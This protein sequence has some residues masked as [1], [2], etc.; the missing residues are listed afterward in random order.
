M[1]P[2]MWLKKK[3]MKQKEENYVNVCVLKWHVRTHHVIPK[4]RINKVDEKKLRGTL[5]MYVC[6]MRSENMRDTG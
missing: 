1:L 3:M 4:G 2:D 6:E 5:N